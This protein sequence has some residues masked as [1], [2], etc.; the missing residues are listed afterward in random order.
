M[1]SW[2]MCVHVCVSQLLQHIYLHVAVGLASA[3]FCW[4]GR[5][6]SSKKIHAKIQWLIFLSQHPSAETQCW[7]CRYVHL[8]VFITNNALRMFEER[9]VRSKRVELKPGKKELVSSCLL[10][11]S[12]SRLVSLF[13]CLIVL[14]GIYI[15]QTMVP[16]P[17]RHLQNWPPNIQRA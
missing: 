11:W 13:H 6:D 15:T 3:G 2:V 1:S 8:V 16:Q 14:Q 5:K 10:I 17:C 7:K 9:P 12:L 4:G